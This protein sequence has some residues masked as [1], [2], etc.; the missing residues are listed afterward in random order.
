MSNADDT[1]DTLRERLS[2]R[3]DF[4]S[5]DTDTEDDESATEQEADSDTTD[6]GAGEDATEQEGDYEDGEDDE[7]DDDTEM[8]MDAGDAVDM[9]VANTEMD[10]E[11]AMAFAEAL[12]ATGESEDGGSTG[13]DDG[14][15]SAEADTDDVEPAEVAEAAADAASEV[16]E[17]ELDERLDGVV[18]ES[19]LDEKLESFADTMV[20]ETE[21][22]VEQALTGSTPGPNSS[23]ATDISKA[24]LFSDGADSGDNGGD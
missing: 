24:D 6:G 22:T 11:E 23:G 19:D 13:D 4:M 21:T 9:L 2:S 10:R 8:E 1:D 3:L 16:V 14:E 7:E 20:D 18:T 5:A 17:Q 15:M 12:G